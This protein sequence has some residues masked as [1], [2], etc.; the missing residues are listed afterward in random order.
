MSKTTR[1]KYSAEFRESSVKLASES[2]QPLSHT[3][4]D[5]GIEKKTMYN[6]VNSYRHQHISNKS[7][8]V[9]ELLRVKRELALVKKERDLLKKAAAYFAKTS[10]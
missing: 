8:T 2:E 3:A 5:L 9:S 7:D 4:S 10:Q 6:W 1:K